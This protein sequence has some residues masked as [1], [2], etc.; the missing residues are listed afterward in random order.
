MKSGPGTVDHL[1]EAPAQE[2][3][4]YGYFRLSFDG[5]LFGPSR[6]RRRRRRRRSDGEENAGAAA[7][8]LCM[9]DA[10]WRS[11]RRQ[12]MSCP[13]YEGPGEHSNAVWAVCSRAMD[14]SSLLPRST[15]RSS[16]SVMV[17]LVISC[18]VRQ[19]IYFAR[20]PISYVGRLKHHSQVIVAAQTAAYQVFPPETSSY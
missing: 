1:G 13:S 18:R 10:T 2:P 14:R 20:G 9:E 8:T 16:S 11:L 7:S 5:C 6:R 12:M 17:R 19:S 4:E 15:G 3:V